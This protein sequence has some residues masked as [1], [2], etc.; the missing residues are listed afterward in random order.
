MA[1][2]IEKLRT[3]ITKSDGLALSNQFVV[4]LPRIAGTITETKELNV[5]CKTQRS[6][7]NLNLFFE[8]SFETQP[9]VLSFVKKLLNLF[10]VLL[11]ITSTVIAEF[12]FTLLLNRFFLTNFDK[13]FFDC[14]KGAVTVSYTHLTLPT[15][16]SV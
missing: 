6:F 5:L 16:C 11:V 9:K 12:I 10:F 15:I 3:Q 1:F 7:L 4:V 8:F 14:G 2:S 13:S